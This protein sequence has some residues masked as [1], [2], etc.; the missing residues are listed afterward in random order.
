MLSLRIG[1]KWDGFFKR[2]RKISRK[3]GVDI[4]TS[5]ETDWRI[6]PEWLNNYILPYL[7]NDPVICEIGPGSGRISQHLIHKAKF[8]YFVDYS[9]Y[10][11]KM[12]KKMYHGKKNIRIIK[13]KHSNLQQIESNTVDFAFSIST[14]VHLYIE[15]IYGYLRECRRILKKTGICVIHF[16]D[17]MDD[18][19]YQFFQDN[20]PKKMR[21]DRRS[22]FRFYHPEMMEKIALK[23]GFRIIKRETITGTRHCFIILGNNGK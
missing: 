6:S 4:N 16:A 22:V 19:G 14:F 11:C 21:C 23:L 20:L 9:R 5:V 2:H 1:G 12:L 15:Q 3:K 13:V 17:F 8:Y 18:G 10:V 7:P